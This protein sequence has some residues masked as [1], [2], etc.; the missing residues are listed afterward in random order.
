MKTRTLDFSRYS[1]FKI[2][3][4]AEVALIDSKA[5]DSSGFFVIGGANNLLIGPNH[6]PL[7]MLDKAF[8]FCELEADCIRAGG[9][10]STGRLASFCRKYDLA[11][12]EF[13]GGLPGTVGGLVA[14]NAGM[15]R[16]E[17]FGRLL[18]VDFGAGRVLA[19]SI[20]HGYRYAK[21]PGVVYEAGFKRESGFDTGLEAEFKA[22]RANQPRDPSA[23]S[24]FKNPPNDYA[25]RLIE[26]VGLK[27]F[28]QGGMAFSDKH[29]NFLVN[30]GGGTYDEAIG[31]IGEAKRRVFEQFGIAL[32]TEIKIL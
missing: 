13:A 14:M 16:W 15:K 6:P 22:M 26:A 4:V 9:A 32:E 24:C 12:L 1:S 11:G 5:F 19:E 2:G 7:A 3:P 28:R 21:L 10:F 20:E 30:T 17:T 27:G 8:D 31:L 29:A 25:G 18:W 23:G